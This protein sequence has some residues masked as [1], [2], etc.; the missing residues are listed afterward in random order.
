[1]SPLHDVPRSDRGRELHE[2]AAA[3]GVSS[4]GSLALALSA[5]EAERWRATQIRAVGD[6]VAV[7]LEPGGPAA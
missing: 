2:I 5:A 7:T 6:Q 3:A 1:M 4:L